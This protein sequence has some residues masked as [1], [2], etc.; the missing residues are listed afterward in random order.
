MMLLLFSDSFSVFFSL[1]HNILELSLPPGCRKVRRF[2]A[3]SYFS[4]LVKFKFSIFQGLLTRFNIVQR[5]TDPAG[6]ALVCGSSAEIVPHLF[7][8]ILRHLLKSYARLASDF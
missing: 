3:R 8:W 6:G 4:S 1:A 7:R 2:L 5:N